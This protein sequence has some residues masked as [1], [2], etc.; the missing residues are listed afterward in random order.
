MDKLILTC[1]DF[2]LYLKDLDNC[3]CICGSTSCQHLDHEL[4]PNVSVE[5]C[6]NHVDE[7]ENLSDGTWEDVILT[8]KEDYYESF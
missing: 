1:E 6:C 8:K 4:F 2:K 3:C 7:I 5:T